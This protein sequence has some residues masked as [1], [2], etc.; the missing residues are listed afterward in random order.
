MAG[1]RDGQ[2]REKTWETSAQVVEAWQ[3][4][5]CGKRFPHAQQNIPKN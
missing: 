2:H 4:I 3:A 1:E 5:G